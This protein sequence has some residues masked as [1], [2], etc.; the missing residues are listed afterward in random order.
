MVSC[1]GL[2]RDVQTI[3][4]HKANSSTT[5][6]RVWKW[7]GTPCHR[8]RYPSCSHTRSSQQR[9]QAYVYRLWHVVSNRPATSPTCSR[10]NMTYI[11]RYLL[12]RST[13]TVSQHPYCSTISFD[14]LL[15]PDKNIKQIPSAG[16][17][18]HLTW[19]R[20][21]LRIIGCDASMGASRSWRGGT[22][23]FCHANIVH[24]E[25]ETW[26]LGEKAEDCGQKKRT[27]LQ[28]RGARYLR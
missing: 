22:G 4:T 26:S 8:C 14:S 12:T 3:P 10:L 25:N 21:L 19:Q 18:R 17:M 6:L 20:P 28:E 13:R 24:F 1:V 2:G 15:L 27:C 23:A 9:L 5:V 11:G 16:K 7:L